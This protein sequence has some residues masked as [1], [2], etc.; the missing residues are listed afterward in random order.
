MSF[1]VKRWPQQW[2]VCL[3]SP[4]MFF[5]TLWAVCIFTFY[6]RLM[7]LQVTKCNILAKYSRTW[8]LSHEIA[9]PLTLSSLYSQVSWVWPPSVNYCQL[10]IL[11]P[12]VN[13]MNAIN[14]GILCPWQLHVSRPLFA[15]I[16]WEIGNSGLLHNTC[17]EVFALFSFS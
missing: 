1:P 10:L 11:M 9:K 17:Y 12:L 5:I 4:P 16:P 14:R 3:I 7:S 8:H 6:D 13:H 2:Y 15:L